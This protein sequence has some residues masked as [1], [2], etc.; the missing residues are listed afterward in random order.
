M[1]SAVAPVLALAVL[2]SGPTAQA[3]GRDGSLMVGV[4]HRNDAVLTRFGADSLRVAWVGTVGAYH[5][6]G[7]G[8]LAWDGRLELLGVETDALRG[9]PLDVLGFLGVDVGLVLLPGLS[10]RG[11]LRGLRVGGGLTLGATLAGDT[12]DGSA[13]APLLRPRLSIGWLETVDAS[14]DRFPFR[15]LRTEIDLAW[16]PAPCS[17]SC[18]SAWRPRPWGGGAGWRPA[19]VSSRIARRPAFPL[20][21]TRN[22]LVADRRAEAHPDD[23]PR[24]RRREV[25]PKARR[26]RRDGRWPAELVARMAELGFL[27]I[28]VP[29][30]HGGAGADNVCY[31]LAMEEISRALCVAPA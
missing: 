15:P 21:S 16:S 22:G 8:S 18:A 1:R 7:R 3:Q 11:L 29:S 27:G 20:S 17:S 30:E 6:I 26:A 25:E 28:A 4:A 9:A 2:L 10:P 31:V 5:R 14:P 23:G 24:L 13:S 19:P 12:A